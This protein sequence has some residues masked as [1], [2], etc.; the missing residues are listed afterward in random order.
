MG[1]AAPQCSGNTAQR[2]DG[3]GYYMELDVRMTDLVK[4][5]PWS[6]ILK[7]LLGCQPQTFVLLISEAFSLV[8]LSEN[9]PSQVMF[10]QNYSLNFFSYFIYFLFFG[11][12]HVA[13]AS[14][15]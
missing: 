9:L 3:P 4:L 10:K 1:W 11:L 14:V 7:L 8:T 6:M 12:G 5:Q 15:F 2:V 13:V